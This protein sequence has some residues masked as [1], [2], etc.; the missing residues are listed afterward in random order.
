M[1]ENF[2]WF[3]MLR[4][5]QKC[6]LTYKYYPGRNHLS[7]TDAEI[8]KI[9]IKEVNAEFKQQELDETKMQFCINCGCGEHTTQECTI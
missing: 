8:N 1:K 3:Y 9:M 5:E 4:D 7:L 6:S 2:R